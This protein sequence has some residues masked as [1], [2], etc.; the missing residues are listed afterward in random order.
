MKF[1]GERFQKAMNFNNFI[2]NRTDGTSSSYGPVPTEAAGLA[3]LRKKDA[4]LAKQHG[5]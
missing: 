5:A 2:G 1:L 3:R 4:G